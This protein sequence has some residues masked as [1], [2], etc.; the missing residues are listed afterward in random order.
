MYNVDG[1]WRI[2]VGGFS[3]VELL[4][5]IGVLAVLA[6]GIIS[7]IGPGPRQGARDGKRKA[8]LEAVRSALEIYRS[9]TGRYPGPDWKSVLTAGGQ[10]MN[11]IPVDP[12]TEGDYGYYASPSGCTTT[13]TRCTTYSLCADLERPGGVCNFVVNNP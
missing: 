2:R 3:L 7:L 4:I 1:M 11:S 8:D 12:K 6:A 10:Y 5:S 13:G 9:D